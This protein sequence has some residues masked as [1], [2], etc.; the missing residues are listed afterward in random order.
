MLTGEIEEETLS[1]NGA[2]SFWDVIATEKS[3]DDQIEVLLIKHDNITDH[4]R[5]L[6]KVSQTFDS[7]EKE[8]VKE[9]KDL[10]IGKMIALKYMLLKTSKPFISAQEFFQLTDED[11]STSRNIDPSIVFFG[12]DWDDLF[13]R[14]R[15]CRKK[16]DH[17]R[18][19]LKKRQVDLGVLSAFVE[20]IQ[21]TRS[22]LLHHY[23]VY[24]YECHKY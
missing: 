2:L 13:R 20:I 16:I 6:Q 24:L 15:L 23:Q 8:T 1:G 4:L 17:S 14:W 21:L 11:P 3:L 12:I 5:D 22:E 18:E 7:E 9:L 10:V 19:M